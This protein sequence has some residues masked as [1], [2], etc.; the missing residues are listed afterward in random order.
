[1]GI[2]RLRQDPNLGGLG[3][4]VVEYM[5]V[6]GLIFGNDKPKIEQQNFQPII[7]KI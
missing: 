6:T 2:G 3:L 7:E 5:K 1:M 4:S